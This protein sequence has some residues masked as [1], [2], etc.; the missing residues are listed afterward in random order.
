MLFAVVQG[1]ERQ[2][3]PQNL[4]KKCENE[5][6]GKRE[7]GMVKVVTSNTEASDHNHTRWTQPTPTK[8]ECSQPQGGLQTAPLK[9]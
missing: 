1:G 8:T 6:R 3:N 9:N 4:G 5:V 7:G 2:K